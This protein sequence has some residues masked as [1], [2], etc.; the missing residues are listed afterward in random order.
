MFDYST[1]V[2][3]STSMLTEGS[4][5]IWELIQGGYSHLDFLGGEIHQLSVGSYATVALI[6]GRIDYLESG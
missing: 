2:I 4:G 6:G 3:E 1:A 5:G